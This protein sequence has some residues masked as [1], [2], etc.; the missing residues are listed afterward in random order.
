[1]G[2]PITG[3]QNPGPAQP[4][5]VFVLFKGWLPYIFEVSRAPLTLTV[6]PHLP[7]QLGF[8]LCAA[9]GVKGA[10]AMSPSSAHSNDWALKEES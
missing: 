6:L 10:A 9:V 7:S 2:Y 1:M 5:Q 3:S 4:N 8:L